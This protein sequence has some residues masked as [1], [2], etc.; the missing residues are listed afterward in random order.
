MLSCV[1]FISF[2]LAFTTFLL[3]AKNEV[4]RQDRHIDELFRLRSAA[5]IKKGFTLVE[6]LV[7]IS[8]MSLIIFISLAFTLNSIKLSRKIIKKAEKNQVIVLVAERIWQ[9]VSSA[10]SILPF[11]STKELFVKTASDE[12]AYSLVG[13]KVRRRLNG[14]T[15]YL[16]SEK[17]IGRLNFEYLGSN[18]VGVSL[19]GKGFVCA[20]K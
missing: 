6:L 2:M 3:A 15:A 10:D 8:I 9:D 19:E 7:S 18:L 11:S 4:A 1:V 5:S 14:Q 16:T 20:I 13:G 17:E 12:V